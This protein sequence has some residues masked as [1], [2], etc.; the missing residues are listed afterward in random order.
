MKMARSARK[1]L[2]VICIFS[3]IASGA[4]ACSG[5]DSDLFAGLPFD[6]GSVTDAGSDAKNNH[7]ASRSDG[8]IFVDGD[9]G[10]GGTDSGSGPPPGTILPTVCGDTLE[11]NSSDPTCCA[12]QVNNGISIASTTY[13]CTSSTSTC[14]ATGDAPISCRDNRDCGGQQCCGELFDPSATTGYEFV[15]CESSC[16][17]QNDAGLTSHV[18][19]CSVGQT[20]DVCAP[21][22]MTCM[23]SNLMPGFNVCGQD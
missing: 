7:D 13:S 19:F 2:V 9:S 18:P 3:S 14:N 22:G 23:P 8:S 17:A 6:G 21:Y 12:M 5:V 15:R 4:L 16:I 11:C 20:P 10:G 1:P